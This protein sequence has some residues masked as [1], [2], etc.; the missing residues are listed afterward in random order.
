MKK[1]TLILALSAA[2]LAASS[3]FYFYRSSNSLFAATSLCRAPQAAAVKGG[4]IS[5]QSVSLPAL[6]AAARRLL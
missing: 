6:A 4:E 5:E 3:A 2:S 1:S